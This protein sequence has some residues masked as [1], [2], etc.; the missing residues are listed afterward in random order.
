MTTYTN[1]PPTGNKNS[2]PI[3]QAY[4]NYF[5]SSIQLDA[6]TLDAITGFFTSRGFESIAA[7][8]LAVVIIAQAKKDNLNPLQI[9]DTMKGLTNV[10][11]S[12]VVAEIINYNRYKT[13]FLGQGQTY[14]TNSEVDRNVLP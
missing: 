13:S 11:I 4:A 8:S 7:Q 14:V 12:A 3:V 10:E 2:E 6:S 5:T 9:I 1:L